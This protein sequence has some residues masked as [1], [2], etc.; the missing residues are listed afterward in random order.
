M[1]Q[2]DTNIKT[3]NGNRPELFAYNKRSNYFLKDSMK[4]YFSI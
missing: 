3:N 4:T 1:Y 2:T